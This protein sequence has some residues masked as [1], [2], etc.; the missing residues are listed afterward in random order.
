MEG[1]NR[2]RTEGRVSAK[3][4]GRGGVYGSLKERENGSLKREKFELFL[5][6]LFGTQDSP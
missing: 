5:E 1:G 6:Y 4:G 3:G 2:S